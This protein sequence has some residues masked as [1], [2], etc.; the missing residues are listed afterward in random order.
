MHARIVVGLKM[1]RFATRIK[2][3]KAHAD[4]RSR[5]NAWRNIDRFQPAAAGTGAIILRHP[6]TKPFRGMGESMP[7]EPPQVYVAKA[8]QEGGPVQ[9][10]RTEK[11]AQLPARPSQVR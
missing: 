11:H 8:I 6:S 1:P 10:D 2:C 7:V 3:S 9:G 5:R 4:G